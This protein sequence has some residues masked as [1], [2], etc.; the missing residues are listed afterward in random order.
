[1]L[2]RNAADYRTLLWTL[3]PAVLIGL[4]YSHPGWIGFLIVPAMY[5]AL[6][7]GVIAHNHNHCPTFRDRGMNSAFANWISIYYGFPTF[8]WIP[9]TT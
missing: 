7:C 5:F 1:M 6:S 8:A 9:R 2:P 4:G 3:V